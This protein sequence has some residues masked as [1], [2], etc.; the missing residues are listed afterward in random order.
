VAKLGP[1]TFSLLG[2]AMSRKI[3]SFPV[4]TAKDD[5]SHSGHNLQKV[6]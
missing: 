5:C 3:N 1:D 2:M 6:P 4:R